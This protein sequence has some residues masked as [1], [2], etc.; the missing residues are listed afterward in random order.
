MK[1]FCWDLQDV[2]CHSERSEES[3]RFQNVCIFKLLKSQ[4]ITEKP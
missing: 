2:I 4:T 3:I 1:S